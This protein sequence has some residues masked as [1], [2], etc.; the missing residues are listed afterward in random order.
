MFEGEKLVVHVQLLKFHLLYSDELSRL[1]CIQIDE[2][3]VMIRLLI[4]WLI[5]IVFKIFITQV[6]WNQSNILHRRN[7]ELLLSSYL[8][9]APK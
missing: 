3:G 9:F 4:L 6:A 5:V 8:L 1:I 7:H 2:I